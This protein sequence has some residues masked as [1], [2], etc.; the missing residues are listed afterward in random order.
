MELSTLN[1]GH[2][3]KLGQV[4]HTINEGVC[5]C[6]CACVCLCMYMYAS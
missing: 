6:A 4:G 3:S 2:P 1:P 5:V